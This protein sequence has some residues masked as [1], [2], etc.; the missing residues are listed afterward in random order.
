MSHRALIGIGLTVYAITLE[1]VGSIFLVR[2]ENLS[3]EVRIPY[4]L[5]LEPC[6]VS[7][8]LIDD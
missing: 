5:V 8:C 2:E 7:F 1:A 4:L 3:I 6:E